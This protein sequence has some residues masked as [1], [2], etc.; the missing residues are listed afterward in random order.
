MSDKQLIVYGRSVFC[1]DLARTQR[2]LQANKIAYTQIDIDLDEAAGSQVEQWVGHRSVPTVVVATANPAVL[3]SEP[4]P[5]PVGRSARS[6]DRGT[7]ITEPS[8]EAL[9]TFLSR[10]GLI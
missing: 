2:F 10:N 1:P 5:L 4:T 9:H 6:Y 8:D 3:V 7:L